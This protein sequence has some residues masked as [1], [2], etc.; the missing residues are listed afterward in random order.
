MALP[1]LLHES[2]LPCQEYSGLAMGLGLDRLV[3]LRK[4]MSDIR[5]LRAADPRIATQMLDLE[6][7]TPV[8]N[9]PAIR[10]DIS[11]AVAAERDEEELGDKVRESLADDASLVESVTLA[12]ETPYERLSDKVR[13]RL[14]LKAGQ[15]NALLRIVLR[16]VD[17]TLTHEE[18]N[19]LRD[20]IY[21]AVHEG[22]T[23]GYVA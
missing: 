3:M 11:V 16:A 23:P 20:D 2:G 21:R 6:P 17:R 18:A 5:L 19:R 8:S 13:R 14:G 4:R 1:A 15:K 22:I 10:Q 7:Y 9:Q 12:D